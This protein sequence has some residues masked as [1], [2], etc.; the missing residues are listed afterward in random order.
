MAVKKKLKTSKV[1]NESSRLVRADAQRN[2]EA[3]LAVALE[4]F[5]TSGVDTPVREIA[6]RAGVGIGTLYRHFPERSD[7]IK[8]AIQNG[9]DAC[10][11]DA[12]KFSA[13]HNPGEALA[14]WL[15]RL[16]D[17]LKTKRGLATALHSGHAAY[18][19]LP[20]YFRDRLTPTLGNLLKAA[21]VAQQIR[22]GV[23][24]DEFLL[25]VMRVATPASEGDIPQAR[26]MVALLVDGLRY[27]PAQSK[28]PSS[29]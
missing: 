27:Q 4:V 20:D 15:Q 18:Q 12:T 13:S 1:T 5:G 9:I 10:V 11:A 8:A 7:L 17:L 6:K 22:P 2:L 24:P 3:I 21:E 25:A 23:D 29:K 14:L 16:I 26:R 28:F 19:S